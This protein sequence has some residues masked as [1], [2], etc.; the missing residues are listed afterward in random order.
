MF[1]RA[2]SLQ[3]YF[4]LLHENLIF[5]ALKKIINSHSKSAMKINYVNFINSELLGCHEK[6]DVRRE[7]N[8]LS[9]SD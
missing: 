2:F 6:I 5:M 1:S 8:F 9:D 3:M 7:E 4:L